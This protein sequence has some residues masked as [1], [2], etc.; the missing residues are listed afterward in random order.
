MGQPP[1]AVARPVYSRAMQWGGHLTAMS[2]A[3]AISTQCRL[4]YSRAMLCNSGGPGTAMSV[5]AAILTQCRPV[6]IIHKGLTKD[7]TCTD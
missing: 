5:A 7:N 6:D 3:A 4:V 1:C 2:V